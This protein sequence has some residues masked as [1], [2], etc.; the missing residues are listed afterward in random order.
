MLRPKTTIKVPIHF[1]NKKPPIKAI[2]EPNPKKGKTQRIVK[3]KKIIEIKNKL[4]FLSSIKYD[5]LSLKKSY[6]VIS[7]RLNFEKKK[8]KNEQTI[9]K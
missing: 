9:N 8:Y 3:V 2:G 7:E 1:P 6:E 4:D 5:R